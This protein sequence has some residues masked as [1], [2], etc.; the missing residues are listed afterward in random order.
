[1]RASDSRAADLKDTRK[2]YVKERDL[3]LTRAFILSSPT[4][5]LAS[6]IF[7]LKLGE[8]LRLNGVSGA[9]AHVDAVLEVGEDRRMW[10]K[11]AFGRGHRYRA[12]PCA[13]IS[14]APPPAPAFVLADSQPVT[15]ARIMLYET[16]LPNVAGTPQAPSPIAELLAMCK[17]TRIDDTVYLRQSDVVGVVE[18]L[19]E[20]IKT[21]QDAVPVGI[22]LDLKEV[23]DCR[24]VS[25]RTLHLICQVAKGEE[26]P[27]KEGQKIHV[28]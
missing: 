21:A 3:E 10:K 8:H 9:R 2:P 4:A 27:F 26:Y 19:L 6:T 28:V 25:F 22:D 7:A 23:R 13:V 17:A 18:L 16:P 24:N 15:G 12:L 14:P 1:M 5:S 11:E 20:A